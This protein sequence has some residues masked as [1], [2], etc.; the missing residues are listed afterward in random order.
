[1]SED[2]EFQ[3]RLINQISSAIEG[4]KHLNERISA[5]VEALGRFDVEFTKLSRQNNQL[6]S[7]VLDV[8]SELG[9]FRVEASQRLNAIFSRLD[10]V[11]NVVDNNSKHIRDLAGENRSYYNDILT[12][13]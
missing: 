7:A 10:E 1:M 9:H 2:L 11:E 3:K 5:N 4:M 12:A 13:L 6:R 8:K